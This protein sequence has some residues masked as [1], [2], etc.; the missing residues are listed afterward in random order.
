MA[1]ALFS[2]NLPAAKYEAKL[3]NPS[4]PQLIQ[5][6][7][8]FIHII[9]ANIYAYSPIDYKKVTAVCPKIT[10]PANLKQ[11][12]STLSPTKILELVKPAITLQLVEPTDESLLKKFKEKQ[13]ALAEIAVS[14][15][16]HALF[17]Q[18]YPQKFSQS[19]S[20]T[21]KE[22]RIASNLPEWFIVKKVDVQKAEA[23]EVLMTMSS[24]Y[25]SLHS[26]Y[27]DLTQL[28]TTAPEQTRKSYAN[29]LTVLSNL[30][31]GTDFEN[32]WKTFSLLSNSGFPPIPST[33]TIGELYP[34][35]KI[36]KPRGNFG[37]KKK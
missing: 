34:E 35:I 29:L 12:L 14:A 28:S 27:G 26:K 16:I 11:T 6:I 7:A 10:T 23:K 22:A 17:A 21:N 32:E 1:F 4:K 3:D 9:S 33:V 20:P 36:P 25:N 8:N 30:P 15:F 18:V 19:G 2:A 5:E 37:K 24:I 13:K 31:T